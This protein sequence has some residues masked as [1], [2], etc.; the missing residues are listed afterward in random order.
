MKRM[1]L[2]QQKVPQEQLQKLRR[3]M[4]AVFQIVIVC[5]FIFAM[6]PLLKPL[7]SPMGV[8]RKGTNFNLPAFGMSVHSSAERT[9]TTFNHLIH[10][11]N[12]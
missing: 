1:L 12:N 2:I 7:A 8:Q 11:F 10:V 5:F 6:K 4:N 9:I 3:L